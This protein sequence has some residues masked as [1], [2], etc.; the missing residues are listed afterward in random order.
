MLSHLKV[1]ACL[2]SGAKGNTHQERLE[3][4]YGGQAA[5]YDAFRDKFLTNR[6][7]LINSLPALEAGQRLLDVG[8]ATGRTLEFFGESIKDFEQVTVLDLCRPLLVQAQKRIEGQ[9]WHNVNTI[10]ADASTWQADKPYNLTIFSYSM[11]MIPD[12]YAAFENAIT[13]TVPGGTIAVVDFYLSRKHASKGRAQHGYLCR[14]FWHWF[15]SHDNV[16]LR[17]DLLPYIMRRLENCQVTET[18]ERIPYTP[19]KVPVFRCWGTTPR[20]E[21]Y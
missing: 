7:A 5:G 20:Q 17:D 11:S 18:M 21:E 3:N 16:F 19:C 9:R 6:Q 2:I 15:F 13:N 12:W 14:H 10:C 4:F 8:G 1:L